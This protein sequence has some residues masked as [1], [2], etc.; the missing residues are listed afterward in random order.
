VKFRGEFHK[1]ENLQ[2]HDMTTLVQLHQENLLLV[3]LE[4]AILAAMAGLY[5]RHRK[6][7]FGADFQAQ[8]AA[9]YG[10]IA[11]A[12][13]VIDSSTRIQYANKAALHLLG[14]DNTMQLSGK[15]LGDSLF[16]FKQASRDRSR[17]N[18]QGELGNHTQLECSGSYRSKNDTD[19]D[20]ELKISKL[21][22]AGSTTH[23]FAV[24][25]HEKNE[26]KHIDRARIRQSL[27]QSQTIELSNAFLAGETFEDVSQK[28]LNAFLA[29][30]ESEYGFVAEVMQ[31]QP[32]TEP[33]LHVGAITNIA[34]NQATR[35]LYKPSGMIFK[36][37]DTL[38]GKVLT[39]TDPVIANKPANDPRA[40]GLP[41]GH[42]PMH[43]FLGIPF[44]AGGKVVGMVGLANNPD[45]YSENDPY[46]LA[47]MINVCAQVTIANRAKNEI[48]FLNNR[49]RQLL[50]E[51]PIMYLIVGTL[52]SGR[53]ILECNQ[54][55]MDITGY[56]F[57]ELVNHSLADFLDAASRTTL[58]SL[59]TLEN[60]SAA[61]S[62]TG[63]LGLVTKKG[64][65]LTTQV[66]L[67]PERDN[68]GHCTLMKYMLV[69]MTNFM[70]IQQENQQL[71][72]E[73]MR[74]IDNVNS[75]VI[76][77]NDKGEITNWNR[78]ISS[79]SGY[80]LLGVSG[81]FICDVNLRL[82]NAALFSE[83]ITKALAGEEFQGLSFDLI[84][85]DGETQNIYLNISTRIA[86]NG[87]L[88]GL[89]IIGQIMTN[90]LTSIS[91]HYSLQKIEAI[92]QLTGG[93]AHDFNNLL[94]IIL[95][96]LDFLDTIITE[97]DEDIELAIKDAISAAKDGAGLTKN[98]LSFARRR[99]LLKERFNLDEALD[100]IIRLCSRSLGDKINLVLSLNTDTD[101]LLDR[102]MLE[103]SI[104]NL[105]I[106]ARD[107]MHGEGVIR[108][109]SDLVTI[110]DSDDPS[111]IHHLETGSWYVIRI[112]DSGSGM[113][114]E[115]KQ[116]AI[117]PFFTTKKDGHGTGLGLSMVY[118][119]IKQSRG[120]MKIE[121]QLGKGTTIN[122]YLPMKGRNNAA[123]P[124]DI[125]TDPASS[126][127]R[128][129]ANFHLLV[130]EDEERVRNIA[131]RTLQAAGFKVSAAD[132]A[133]KALQLMESQH[134]DLVFSDIVMPGKLDGKELANIIKRLFPDVPVQLTSG[135]DKTAEL[136][137][138]QSLD[139]LVKPYSNNQLIE[140]ITAAL[141][142]N[143]NYLP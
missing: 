82:S 73:F 71:S 92:G 23:A 61:V 47:P 22:L 64:Q 28:M 34:W 10:D 18:L 115:V 120:E 25:I 142:Q 101:V 95:G 54:K 8:C 50:D 62:T 21:A 38:W 119:F 122:L 141:T 20:L 31:D 49:Y 111:N 86:S 46:F 143:Y 133:E 137:G 51:A 15:P 91:E 132:S 84:D 32:D 6:S 65:L 81:K 77:T 134:F 66:T 83:I 13:L 93:V 58:E 33:Y 36:G 55:F 130:V 26:Q 107:A 105:V 97:K 9:F 3:L 40:K 104:L 113:S 16:I 128:S 96:N 42:P 102:S 116:H 11:T 5:L 123:N 75:I 87:K 60:E 85:K 78:K 117:E 44:K 56:Q 118:G 70:D 89:I 63:T 74:V 29:I 2:E 98:L 112:T 12:V 110:S 69:D 109:T 48:R 35:D 24:L 103:S 27:L 124:D 114:D 139:I 135:Y 100:N 30:T 41:K 14:M 80:D 90:Y 94:T 7:G 39:T 1:I 37:L 59:H 53:R 52:E 138:N 4:V 67:V 79:L 121:S 68:N 126:N 136:S 131:V 140:K 129:P 76:M 127:R 106:N 99:P 17:L 88:Q 72:R 45:G 57:S 43:N 108:I 125:S 19:V